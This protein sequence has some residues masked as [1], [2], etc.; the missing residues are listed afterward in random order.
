M[1][2]SL[3]LL[4]IKAKKVNPDLVSQTLKADQLFLSFCSTPPAQILKALP[5][6]P[7]TCWVS[8]GP[9]LVTGRDFTENVPPPSLPCTHVLLPEGLHMV[10]RNSDEKIKSVPVCIMQ[11]LIKVC[12]FPLFWFKNKDRERESKIFVA[13]RVMGCKLQMS[14]PGSALL[15]AQPKKGREKTRKDWVLENPVAQ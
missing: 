11:N 1:Q 14:S 5:N 3:N 10:F 12:K 6:S 2:G 7:P 4:S 8:G 15:Q 13:S 9:R